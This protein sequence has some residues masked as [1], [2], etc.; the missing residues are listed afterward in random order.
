MVTLSLTGGSSWAGEPHLILLRPL[1]V[2]FTIIAVWKLSLS[3]LRRLRDAWIVVLASFF[4]AAFH[5]LPLPYDIWSLL[6]G[7]GLIGEIDRITANDFSWRPLS[8]S[9]AATINSVA[10]LAVPICV[11]SICSLL[12]NQDRHKVAT[13]VFSL[14]MGSAV[15]GYL[16]SL[17]FEVKLYDKQ[18]QVSGIFVNRNHQAALLSLAFPI[19]ALIWKR[20]TGF[21]LQKSLEKIMVIA[22]CVLVVPIIFITGSRAGVFLLAAA[23]ILIAVFGLIPVK[24]GL[25]R[26]LLVYVFFLSVV[27]VLAGLS[28]FTARDIALGRL[29][30][31]DDNLR[32]PVWSNILDIV[33]LYMPWGSGAGSYDE[34][35][36]IHENSD[37]LRPTYSN[38]A[39][40]EWLEILL[41]C[42]IPGAFILVYVGIVLCS[43]NY[44]SANLADDS[45]DFAKVGAST[46][47]LLAIAST[48]DYPVRTP[49]LAAV[50]VIGLTWLSS[51]RC[52]TN[53]QKR[54]EG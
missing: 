37:L 19:G 33:P 8:M 50:A 23:L 29:L 46:I 53:D 31:E 21:G 40:N 49:I 44:R 47:I 3:D 11:L 42:G 32:L 34:V 36:R 39:H 17:G 51:A 10:A 18:S 6:P 52:F 14:I 20:G 28:V 30:A 16:Q 41:T 2:A 15:V 45:G 5:I 4:V 25:L 43:A 7:R 26:K 38:H 22:G 1:S 35:Y 54:L 24:A 27:G 13:L 9:P 48:F 12:G